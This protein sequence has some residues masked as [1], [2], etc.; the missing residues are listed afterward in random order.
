MEDKYAEVFVDEHTNLLSEDMPTALEYQ[1]YNY[2]KVSSEEVVKKEQEVMNT[3]WLPSN[4]IVLL[5]RPLE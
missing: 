5:T 1:F 4:P 3:T 2:G